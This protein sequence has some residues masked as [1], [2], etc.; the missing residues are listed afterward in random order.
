MSSST[1]FPLFNRIQNRLSWEYKLLTRKLR[2]NILREYRKFKKI[3][4]MDIEGVKIPLGSHVSKDIRDA[5]YADLYEEAEL[6]IVKSQLSSDDVVMEIGTGVGLISSYCA[7]RIGSERVFTYE[8]NPGL[9]APIR[10]TYKLNQVS[11]KLEICLVGEQPGEQT[12]Y[13]G[14]NFWSSSIIQRSS[15]FKPIQVPVK[16]FN[17]EIQRINPTF[18]IID[19]EG[20]EYELMQYANLHNVKKILIELHERVIGHEK[21]KFVKDK[22]AGLGFQVN[23]KIST[24][25]ELF[26]ERE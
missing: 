22:L 16:P 9:E 23:K 6:R 18:L 4:I 3:S 7:Q 21:V 1:K 20:G 8:A 2:Q 11:P 15:E 5:I 13:V 26:L 12:F 24:L 19:I 14:E 17:E 25:E 10:E